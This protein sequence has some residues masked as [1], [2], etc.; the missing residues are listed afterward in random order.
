MVMVYLHLPSN[1][2]SLGKNVTKVHCAQHVPDGDD[3]DDDDDDD[4]GDDDGD[5]DDDD[6]GDDDDDDDNLRVV[7]ARSL[8]DPL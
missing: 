5:D 8:A 7:A 1:W 4:D 6:D 3:G 2:L